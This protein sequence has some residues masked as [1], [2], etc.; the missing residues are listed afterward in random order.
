M[1]P[2]RVK[3]VYERLEALDDRLGHRLRARGGPSR[4]T[5]EQ[6]EDRLKDVVEYSCELRELVRDL[7]VALS[8]RPQQ[9]A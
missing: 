5:I 3:E 8:T 9:K 2:Q 4:A 1:D 7:I 6:I